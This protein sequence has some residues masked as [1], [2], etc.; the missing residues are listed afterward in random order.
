MKREAEFFG[1]AELVLIYIA[2]K[3]K[4]ALKLEALL[5]DSGVDYLVEADHYQGGLV[6]RTERVGAF[7]Y[8]GTTARETA[9]RI[10]TENGYRPLG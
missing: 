7:F 8:V 9:R 2:R 10:L 6:F 1:D 3:L 4:E 5:T